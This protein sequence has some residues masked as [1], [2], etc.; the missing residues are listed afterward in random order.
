MCLF[1]RCLINYCSYLLKLLIKL[2]SNQRCVHDQ[3][4]YYNLC[5]FLMY[6]TL[7]GNMDLKSLATGKFGTQG[8]ERYMY[9]TESDCHLP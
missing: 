6:T 8:P 1:H 4:I 3:Y 2:Q 5:P 9:L 7:Y